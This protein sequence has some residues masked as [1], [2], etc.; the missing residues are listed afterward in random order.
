M[1]RTRPLIAIIDDDESVSRALRRLVRSLGMNADTFTSGQEFI[2]L[3]EA[4]PSFDADCVVL[5]V[6]MPGLDGL[7]VQRRLVRSGKLLPVI[8][9]T[10]RDELGVQERA[11]AAGA[12]A[13]LRKPFSDEL[14]VKTLRE[15]FKRSLG[16]GQEG[17]TT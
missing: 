11:M 1:S 14:F 13:F 4:A 15:A 10:G 3:I 9:I 17:G 7:E 8:F 6:H 16:G 5:D 12:V 2:D